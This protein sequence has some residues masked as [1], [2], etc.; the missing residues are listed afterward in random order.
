MYDRI[1]AIR[2]DR[3]ESFAKRDEGRHASGRSL[4]KEVADMRRAVLLCGTAS[5]LMAF[6]GG[7]LAFGLVA[8]SSATA[9]SSQAQEVRASAFVLVGP[10]GNTVIARLAP[11]DGGGASLVLF[12]PNG[13][14]RTGLIVGSGLTFWTGPDGETVGLRVGISGPNSDESFNGVQLGPDG[15]ISTLPSLP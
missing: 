6:L 11:G 7:I 5:F 14:R 13:A 1:V 12:G 4:Q 2:P 9:Q 3:R 8:P 10:D 15:S